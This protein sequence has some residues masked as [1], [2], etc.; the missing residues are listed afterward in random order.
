M[1]GLRGAVVSNRPV[2]TDAPPARR[3]RARTRSGRLAALDDY[4]VR[5]ERARLAASQARFV[6]VGIGC[7]PV[8]LLDSMATLREVAPELGFVGIELEDQFARI[9]ARGAPEADIRQGGFEVVAEVAPAAVIRVMNVLRTYSQEDVPDVHRRLGDALVDGGLVIEG[10]CDPEGDNMSAHL[11]RRRDDAVHRE[12]L[13][14]HT[15]FTNGFAPMLLRDRLPR[16]LR[17]RVRPDTAI[18]RFFADWNQA[19]AA[20]RDAGIKA[21]AACFVESARRLARVRPGVAADSWLL[22]RGYLLWRPAD[23]V[24]L[25]E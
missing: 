1:L 5:F 18:G 16:D 21:P 20:A 10:T 11:L 14:F 4:L 17:R 3:T 7:E 22:E 2:S 24:P 25:P 12:G 9:A 19:F 15:R 23:G 13:L 8:T 6:D